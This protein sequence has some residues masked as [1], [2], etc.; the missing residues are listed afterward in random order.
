MEIRGSFVGGVGERFRRLGAAHALTELVH[1]S[2]GGGNSLKGVLA[3]HVGG[4][5]GELGVTG[6]ESFGQGGESRG[7]HGGVLV[8]DYLGLRADSFG[9]D[10][11][12]VTVRVVPAGGGGELAP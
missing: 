7:S 10:G 11:G 8:L 6:S 2:F 1:V 12:R 9:D 4:K 3:E 5:S